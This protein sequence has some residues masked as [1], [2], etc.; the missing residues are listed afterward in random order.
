MEI[1]IEGASQ[2]RIGEVKGSIGGVSN[3]P[4]QQS[5]IHPKAREETVGENEN[6]SH[7]GKKHWKMRKIVK[8]PGTAR[9]QQH[10]RG[11]FNVT[12]SIVFILTTNPCTV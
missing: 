3:G 5:L 10:Q 4:P 12:S 2:Q 8:L 6:V 1:E 9:M 11:W 7:R